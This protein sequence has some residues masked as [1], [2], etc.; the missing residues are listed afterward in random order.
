MENEEIIP[1]MDIYDREERCQK[2]IRTVR[3][4]IFM[5]LVVAVLMLWIVFTNPAQIWA[6]GLSAFV[7]LIDLS[8]AIPLWMEL[9]KQ[10]KLLHELIAMEDE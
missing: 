3:K 5:R 10:K 1:E 7:L 4:A 9:K 8:G 6:W 2:T